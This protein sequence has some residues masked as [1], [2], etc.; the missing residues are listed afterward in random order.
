M[1]PEFEDETP[2]NPFDFGKAQLQTQTEE[3]YGYWNYD[4]SEFDRVSPLLD[5]DEAMEQRRAY[6][7]S[8]SRTRSVQIL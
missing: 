2:I 1:Q 5:D 7:L 4:S 6:S 3:G 8:P